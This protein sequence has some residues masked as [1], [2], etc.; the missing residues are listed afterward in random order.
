V[1]IFHAIVLGIVQGLSEFL[2][3]SSSAHLELV[4][5]LFGWDDFGSDEELENAFDVALH[6]GTMIGAVAYLWADVR[7]LT[8]AGIGNLVTRR[9]LGPDGRMAWLIV[10]AAVPAALVAL[11]L[12]PLLLDLS[13]DIAL[14]AV[15]LIV[16]GLVLFAADQL[17]S[18]RREAEFGMRDALLMGTG[19]A[20]S[21]VPGVSRSGATI[22]V[23]RWL[24]FDRSSAARIAFLM[25]LPTIAGA[26]LIRGGELALDGM[27]PG[28]AG[29]FAA[30]LVS[31]AV[32]GWFAVWFTL[33]LVRTR[34]F[35]PFVI[36]RCALGVAILLILASSFR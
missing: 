7:R 12:E 2:P 16:F 8:V 28:M 6:V 24:R 22:T 29:A 4:P 23:G 1:P 17:P 3:I 15:N 20:L 11:T 30:G 32:T 18:S 31:S 5:W 13:D 34:T 36:Y 35:L 26:A 27:P 25:S 33:K 10:L 21:L 9:P 19:Q 14:I